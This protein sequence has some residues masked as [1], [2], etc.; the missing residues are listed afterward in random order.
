[1]EQRK[2]VLPPTW[3]TVIYGRHNCSARSKWLFARPRVLIAAIGAAAEDARPCQTMLRGY[4]RLLGILLANCQPLPTFTKSATTRASVRYR[5]LP[6][7]WPPSTAA[8]RRIF[9]EL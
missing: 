3:P 4:L 1:M 7:V 9:G 5:G 2:A 8:A 6:F